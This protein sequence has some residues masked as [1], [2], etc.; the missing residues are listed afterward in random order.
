MRPAEA[1]RALSPYTKA[2][3][4]EPIIA[5]GTAPRADAANL[6]SA[7]VALIKLRY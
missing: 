4:S 3:C 5:F 1:E 6:M 7:R 2:R